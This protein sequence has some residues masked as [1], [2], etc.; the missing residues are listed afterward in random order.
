M[1][2]HPTPPPNQ[3]RIYQLNCNASN[4]T[5]LIMLNSLNPID[6]DI[7]ALQEPYIDFNGVTRATHPW[8]VVYPSRHYRFPKET[9]SVMLINKNL[10]TN[11]WESLPLDTSDITAIRMS[12]DFGKIRIFNVYNDCTHS[13]TLTCLERYLLSQATTPPPKRSHLRHMAWRLQ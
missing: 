13:R 11:H 7:V 10:A 1:S 6:W 9:R 4:D 8:R 2:V 3:L 5:Q 12:G